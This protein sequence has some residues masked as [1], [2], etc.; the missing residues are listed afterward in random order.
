V[1]FA[2]PGLGRYVIQSIATRDYPAVQGAV[3]VVA[4]GYVLINVLVD[5]AYA[6]LDPRVR[7]VA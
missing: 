4:A 7:H 3:L 6:F 5:L 2:W 1:V